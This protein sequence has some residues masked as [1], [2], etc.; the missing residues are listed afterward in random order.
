ML[1]F[2]TDLVVTW[3][4]M[5]TYQM[6]LLGKIHKFQ[7]LNLGGG[8]EIKINTTRANSVKHSVQLFWLNQPT[9]GWSYQLWCCADR[10]ILKSQ[11]FHYSIGHIRLFPNRNTKPAILLDWKLNLV[12]QLEKEFVPPLNW[13]NVLFVSAGL[14]PRLKHPLWGACPRCYVRVNQTQ[15]QFSTMKVEKGDMKESSDHKT[16]IRK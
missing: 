8:R 14:D 2:Y 10:W 15:K 9:E 11:Y 4:L 3:S 12:K 6:F 7:A 16:R 13:P 5:P 1:Y